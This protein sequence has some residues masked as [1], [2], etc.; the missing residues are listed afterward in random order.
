MDGL[1]GKLVTVQSRHF[2]ITGELTV[3]SDAYC[4]SGH[5][6]F[7]AFTDKDVLHIRYYEGLSQFVILLKG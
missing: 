5:M 2:A 7:C 3:V 4:I 6:R 1:H